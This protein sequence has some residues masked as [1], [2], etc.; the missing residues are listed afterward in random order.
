MEATAPPAT[1]S[2]D[3]V[4]N[5]RRDGLAVSVD[6]ELSAW[7]F[8]KFMRVSLQCADGSN[9][10]MIRERYA[11]RGK[12]A[13]SRMVYR[14]V[15]W[16]ALAH[17]QLA[18]TAWAQFNPSTDSPIAVSTD[19]PER[20][21]DQRR[22]LGS[23]VRV[24]FY[25]RADS[26]ANLALAAFWTR[27]EELEQRLSHYR[28]DSEVSRLCQTQQATTVSDDLWHVL[29][30]AQSI[31]RLS[32]GAFDVTVGPYV[33][34]WKRGI[35]QQHVPDND[36]IVAEKDRVGYRLLQLDALGKTVRVTRPQMRLDLSGIAKG[37]IADQARLTLQQHG[38]SMAMVDVGGDLSVGKPPPG[39]TG[40]RI[41]IPSLDGDRVIALHDCGV[42]SSGSSAQH[43]DADGKRY[44]HLLDPRTGQAVLGRSTVTVVARNGMLADGLASTISVL[45]R[46]VAQE[47]VQDCQN[48]PRVDQNLDFSDGEPENGFDRTVAGEMGTAA[49]LWVFHGDEGPAVR[50]GHPSRSGVVLPKG[51]PHGGDPRGDTDSMRQS[52]SQFEQALRRLGVAGENP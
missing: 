14:C 7:W 39:T 38:I 50:Q 31:S 29:S 27:M 42:A 5:L 48:R 11:V 45:G 19:S 25:A 23:L 1:S 26:A 35:R 4:R 18:A 34:L 46:S 41:A 15:L 40:W 2:D 47:L 3:W 6:V 36:R 37:Y 44:S 21:D 28:A 17:G 52:W 12:F 30:T 49:V 43:L 22:Q 32:G 10:P 20:Y 9:V 51:D 24:S 8:S 33:R 16:I 13:N